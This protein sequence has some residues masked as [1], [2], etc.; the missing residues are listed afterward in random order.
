VRRRPLGEGVDLAGYGP[1][2]DI[3]PI[4]SI[5]ASRVVR[6]FSQ[7]IW[8][9]RRA[10]DADDVEAC[11]RCSTRWRQYRRC[12]RSTCS[13]P[14]CWRRWA[15]RRHGPG[16]HGAHRA[17]GVSGLTKASS[18]RAVLLGRDK[19]CAACAGSPKLVPAR[20]KRSVLCACGLMRPCTT[21]RIKPVHQ[22]RSMS[23]ER[24]NAKPLLNP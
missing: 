23:G 22:R 4:S 13:D 18:S 17:R 3:A 2:A 15:R 12:R 14:H 5:R 16:L 24:A 9:D 10:S 6:Y 1:D 20:C 21:W 7:R 19:V 8:F 11:P